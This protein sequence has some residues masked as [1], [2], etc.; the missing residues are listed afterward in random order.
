MQ[1]NAGDSSHLFFEQ[2]GRKG[3]NKLEQDSYK[4]DK[5]DGQNIKQ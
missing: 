3:R 1:V 5:C 4:G 2:E